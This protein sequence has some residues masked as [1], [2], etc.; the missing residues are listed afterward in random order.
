M[1]IYT[2]A[3]NT[4]RKLGMLGSNRR[5][6]L[7]ERAFREVVYASADLKIQDTSSLT[8]GSAG[9]RFDFVA[10]FFCGRVRF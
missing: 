7:V 2:R 1:S 3:K 9:F 8:F 4:A 5:G 10:D 6:D